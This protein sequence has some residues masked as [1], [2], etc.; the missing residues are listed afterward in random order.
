LQGRAQVFRPGAS[1]WGRGQDSK[2]G[3]QYNRQLETA[4]GTVNVACT[5]GT[6]ASISLDGGANNKSGG[7]SGRALKSGTSFLCYEVYQDAGLV[8]VS[9]ANF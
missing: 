8:T 3:G 7:C 1:L 2:Q 4:D 6:T 5:T 9:R